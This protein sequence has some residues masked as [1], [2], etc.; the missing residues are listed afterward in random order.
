M[1]YHEG[2]IEAID[3]KITKHF[4]AG[5]EDQLFKFCNDFFT[6][7]WSDKEDVSTHVAKLLTL[8]N[9]LNGGLVATK[10]HALLNLLFIC[11]VMSIL[12]KSFESFKSSWMLIEKGKD[13]P[14]NELTSKLCMFKRN[15]C[16]NSDSRNR[17]RS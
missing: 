14:L 8:W 3:G 17:E 15:F 7:S 11:K 12:A 4:E 9:E 10:E 5:S 6:F 16:G 1:D 2:A 13:K